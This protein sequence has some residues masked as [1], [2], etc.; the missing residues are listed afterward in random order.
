[1]TKLKINQ[2]ADA[3]AAAEKQPLEGDELAASISKTHP[4]VEYID[5][6][7]TLVEKIVATAQ[8]GDVIV[9]LGSHGFRGMI[10]ET[11]QKLEK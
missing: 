1:L 6:D 4:H 5:N 8:A 11:I 2:D 7:K 3:H 10:E 9:F